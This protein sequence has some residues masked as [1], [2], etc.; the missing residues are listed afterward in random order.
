MKE[1][2]ENDSKICKKLMNNIGNFPK[3]DYLNIYKYYDFNLINDLFQDIIGNIQSIND[4]SKSLQMD[5]HF[6]KLK[7]DIGLNINN[8]VY[9]H[10]YMNNNIRTQIKLFVNYIHF[11][12]NLHT[13]YLTNFIT[14]MKLMHARLRADINLD[15]YV[16]SKN[17]TKSPK[18]MKKGTRKENA[19]TFLNSKEREQFDKLLENTDSNNI[20]H[21]SMSK[22]ISSMSPASKEAINSVDYSSVV[23]ETVFS[24]NELQTDTANLVYNSVQGE[25]HKLTKTDINTEVRE[26]I[27]EQHEELLEK[28]E[29]KEELTKNTEKSEKERLDE[30]VKFIEEDN[31]GS[32]N[33]PESKSKKRRR[34][35]KKKQMSVYN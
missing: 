7:G 27:V 5:L 13:K 19:N 25:K 26:E 16:F 14:N 18:I 1:N 29:E 10:E 32:G 20:I 9:G 22:L 15:E 4:H 6:Y 35:K 3:Y 21:R 34:R 12:L 24:D 23:D 8:F 11:F 2:F 31:E 33:V 17:K 28:S 30:L